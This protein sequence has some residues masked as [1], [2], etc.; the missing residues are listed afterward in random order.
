MSARLEGPFLTG[1]QQSQFVAFSNTFWNLVPSATVFKKQNAANN[2]TLSYT[3]RIS[4]PSI[5]D[6]NPNQNAQDP[7]NIEVGNPGLRPELVDQVEFT[8]A[9]QTDA[10]FFLNLSLFGRQTSNSIESIIQTNASGLATITQQNLASNRQ[11]GLN[12]SAS[13]DILPNW[14]I[15]GNANG[16]YASFQSGALNIYT[17]GVAWGL[18]LNHSWKLPSRFSLQAYTDFDA[19]SVTLQG[20]E[21]AWFYY[22]FSAKKEFPAR[23]LTFTLTAV[24]PFSTYL[25]QTELTRGTDFETTVHN[26]YLQRSIRVSLNWE[27]G[28]LFKAGNRLK[29]NNDDQKNAKNGG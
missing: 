5:W 1:R 26:R 3:R 25:S 13:L 7:N 4:R 2:L 24:S 11:V 9:L 27:F 15:N 20:Y 28:G 16:R 17:S 8:Y 21:G 29:I 14:K 12:L 19:R 22:S 23:K 6:L 18:N 10:D